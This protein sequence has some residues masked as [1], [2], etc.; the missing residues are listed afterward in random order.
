MGDARTHNTQFYEHNPAD[1]TILPL[2]R[3][4][5]AQFS[6]RSSFPAL[7]YISRSHVVRFFV[8]FKLIILNNSILRFSFFSLHFCLFPSRFFRLFYKL[9]HVWTRI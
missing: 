3:V 9:V 4:W 5:L 1:P 2:K 6:V 7:P 8:S